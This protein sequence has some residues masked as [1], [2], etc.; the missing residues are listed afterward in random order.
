MGKGKAPKIS[1][2]YGE[3]PKMGFAHA[4]GMISFFLPIP[5]SSNH[6][7]RVGRNGVFLSPA[8]REW[9]QCAD[10]AATIQS[11]PRNC[12]AVPVVVDFEIIH[13]EG[14]RR[15]R[16][17]NNLPKLLFDWLVA[18]GILIDDSWDYCHAYTIGFGPPEWT[19][20]G[21]PAVVA[22]TIYP[23]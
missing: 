3:S 10:L 18:W 22:C 6:I 5:P 15:G 16:D 20:P 23:G 4:A 12:Y 1:G 19:A 2:K 13:G 8:A 9:R 21:N 7:W 11:V 14:F 17:L